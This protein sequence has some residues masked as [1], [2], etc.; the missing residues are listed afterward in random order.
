M[1]YKIIISTLLDS[2]AN[3]NSMPDELHILAYIVRYS[4]IYLNYLKII[5]NN[6]EIEKTFKK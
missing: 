1:N 5:K 3:I 6:I 4:D 2:I